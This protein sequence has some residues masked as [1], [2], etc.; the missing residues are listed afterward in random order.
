[1][2]RA[3][4]PLA[5]LGRWGSDRPLAGRELAA[6]LAAERLEALA[7]LGTSHLV[8][9]PERGRHHELVADE[10]SQAF[11]H[12]AAVAA[13]GCQL[14]RKFIVANPARRFSF[15]RA[16]LSP[17]TQQ[18]RCVGEELFSRGRFLCP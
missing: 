11:D 3:C 12:Y 8:I 5:S 17:P 10:P 13:S 1:M 2:F 18:A 7:A 9:I 16:A 6:N 14:L 4:S 15:A